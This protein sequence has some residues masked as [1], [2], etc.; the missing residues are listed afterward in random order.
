MKSNLF[1]MFA[2]LSLCIVSQNVA[3]ETPEY[4]RGHDVFTTSGAAALSGKTLFVTWPAGA[5]AAERFLIAVDVTDATQPK[6][7]DRL[8]L[9][10]FPQDLALDGTWAYVVN[11]RDVLVIDISDPSALQLHGSLRIDENPMRGPQGIALHD[12]YAWL[13][14]RRGGVRSVNISDPA[15]PETAGFIEVPA[16]T[17]GATVDDGLLY[18]AGDTRGVFTIDIADAANP[19]LLD[20][21]PAPAG[22]VGRMRSEGEH[23]WLAAGNVLI[24]GLGRTEPV[25]P[26]WLGYT[27]CRHV[28]TP[29]YGSYAHDLVM[30]EAECPKTAETRSFA[31]IAD[32]ESGLIVVDLLQPESPRFVGG[33]ASVEFGAD[34]VITGLTSSDSLVY[35]IDELFGVRI[36]DISRI[37]K[38]IQ[39]G[40]GLDLRP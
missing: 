39:I 4:G 31:A 23:I 38:P 6:L 30:V 36:I 28:L 37:D 5:G 7:L 40:E 15:N 21:L 26:V 2:A 20:R 11:G 25:S 14:C 33:V 18:V 13:A 12:G 3:S 17:R 16:F 19:R 1:L 29:Y 35:V 32:G 24:A 34:C 10:G 8:T 9:D 22:S 27:T